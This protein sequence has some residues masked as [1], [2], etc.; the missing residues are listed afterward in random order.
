MYE[1]EKS[2]NGFYEQWI[3]DTHENNPKKK[4]LLLYSCM[5]F[6]HGINIVTHTFRIIL[7]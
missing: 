6:F 5:I 1:C 7:F 4:G 3:C 2:E